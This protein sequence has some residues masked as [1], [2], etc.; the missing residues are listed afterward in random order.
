MTLKAFIDESG[1]G[2][3]SIFVMAGFIARAEEWAKFNDDWNAILEKP[4]TLEYFHMADAVARKDFDR[5]QEMAAIIRRYGWQEREH[6]R[7]PDRPTGIR[8]GN[9]SS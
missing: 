3:P 1:K 2:D 6:Q 9:L 8:Q 4:P 7:Q 5:I